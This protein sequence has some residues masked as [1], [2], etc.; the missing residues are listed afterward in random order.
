MALLLVGIFIR[1]FGCK[2]L[3]LEYSHNIDNYRFKGT[4]APLHLAV[5]KEFKGYFE[6]IC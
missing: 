6:F 4:M 1:H 2:T 3:G 5:H